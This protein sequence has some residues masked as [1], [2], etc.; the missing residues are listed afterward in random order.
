MR[1]HGP[2]ALAAAQ[3]KPAAV[4]VQSMTCAEFNDV[5]TLIGKPETKATTTDFRFLHLSRHQ[6]PTLPRFATK[7]V[8]TLPT[9]CLLR[10]SHPFASGPLLPVGTCAAM[11][12]LVDAQR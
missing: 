11:A 10:G 3:L 7:P 6:F 8:Q 1:Q 12:E 5:F 9:Q 4:V 2:Q